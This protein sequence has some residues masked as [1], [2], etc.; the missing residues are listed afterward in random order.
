MGLLEN[1]LKITGNDFAG[2]V[3]DGNDADVESYID[4]GSYSFNAA[5]SGTIYGGFPGN[6]VTGLA[7]DESTGKTFFALNAAEN[8]LKA[9][10]K[11]MVFYFEAE[12]ALTTGML[13]QRNIPLDRIAIIPVMTIQEFRTQTV[14]VLDTYLAEPES[15]RP[16]LFM[17]LDSLGALSTTKEITDTAAG[18]ETKDMTAAQVTRGAFR[19]L[20]LKLG[21][22]K[23]ALL[24][25]NHTYEGMG[26]FPTKVMTKGKG[27]SY[28]AS[29]IF[30]L[31]KS[32]K[33]ETDNE[34]TGAIIT[35]FV[36][37][38]RLT[39]E[40]KKVETLL[41]YQQG[42]NR[43]YGLLPIAER[44]GVIK[45]LSKQYEFP[46]QKPAFENHIYKNPEKFFTKE[47]LD[48]IDEACQKEFKY[49]GGVVVEEDN[50][51]N[52]E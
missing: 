23:V 46:G 16:P 20:T 13:K 9:F 49:G 37:K 32:K 8:F 29:S 38:S 19:V 3:S 26:M 50:E 25:V 24:V 36:N 51:P 35:V 1:L 21:R 5:I 31:S 22:A 39:V 33:K 44:H 18:L 34:V 6:K 27:L 4:T 42:L 40:N 41:D 45:K 14:K 7:G 28:A 10:P 2:K 15:K 11:G 52:E 30:Y 48:K 17:V 12:S 43:Y 47:I